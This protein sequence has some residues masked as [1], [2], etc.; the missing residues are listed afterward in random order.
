[1]FNMNERVY[2]PRSQIQSVPHQVSMFHPQA[3]QVIYPQPSMIH[4]QSYQV[5]HPQSYQVIHQQTSQAPVVSLQSSADP[6][7]VDS[8]LVVP[9]LLP[10]DDPLKCLN[11]V[12]TFMSTI[13]ALSYPSSN[14]QIETS[15]NP[16]HQVAMKERHALSYVDNSSK[17][18]DDMARKYTHSNTV[19]HAECFKKKMLLAQLQE[20]GIQL[21]D[22]VEVYDLDCDDVPD[23]QP[24]QG[25]QVRPSSVQSSVVNHSETK[26]TSDSNII[27]YSQYMKELQQTTINLENKSVNDSLT[28]EL[29]RYKEQVKVLKEGQKVDLKSKDNI[30]DSC[31]QSVKIDRLKQTLSEHLKEKESLMQTVTLLKNDFKKEESRNID[32]EIAIEKKIKQLDNIVYKRDQSTQTKAQQLKPKLYDGNVIKNTSAIMILDSK[33]TLMLAE[34]CRLKMLLKQQDLMVLEKKV[35]T[36]PVDYAILVLLEDPPKLRFRKNFLKSACSVARERHDHKKLKERIN[37]LSGN[38]NEDKV[39]KDIEEI[40]TINIELDHRVLAITALKEELRKLKGKSVVSCRESVN[41]PKVIAPVVH[42][43]ELE[44][45]SP[46]LKNNREAHVD[47]IRITKENVDTLRDVVKQAKTSNPLDKALA[48][49]LNDRARAK[50]VKS[51][52]MKEWKPTVPPKIPVKSTV[53]TNKKPSSASQWRLKETNHASSSSAPK[54]VE[55]RTANHLEPNN[56]M[57]SNVSISPSSSV[58]CKSY[59]SYLDNTSGPVP[60]RKERCTLQCALSSKEDKSS[61]KKDIV[62]YVSRYLTCLKVKTEHQRPFGLL[63]QPEIPK[64]KWKRIAM[65]FVTK[66][67]RTSSGHDTIWVISFHIDVLANN[68]R[69]IRNVIPLDEIRVDA[70][71]NFV[72]EPVEI[73]KREFKK[74]KQ[75]RIAIVKVVFGRRCIC[76]FDLAT[77]TLLSMDLLWFEMICDHPALASYVLAPA[78]ALDNAAKDDDI[79]CWYVPLHTRGEYRWPSSGQGD[80][81]YDGVDEVPKLSTIIAQQLQNLLPTILAQVGNQGSNQR[82]PRNQNGNAV[83]D[84]IQGDVR[85]VIVNNTTNGLIDGVRKAKSGSTLLF[86]CREEFCLVNEMQKLETEFWNHDKAGA[87]HVAYTDRFHELDRVVQK[88]GT[89]TDEAARIESQKKNREKR[90]NGGVPNRDRNVRDENKRT[91]T[92]NAFATT[93]N[94]VRRQYNGS[95]LKYVSCNLHHPPEIPCRPC[96]NCGRPRHMAKDCRVA[97]RMVNQMNARNPTDAPGACYEYGGTDHFKEACPR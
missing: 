13:L 97:P 48:Y 74:L 15:S 34:E 2:N 62:V 59:K 23:V 63:Q 7:L 36:T 50:A 9:Y 45:L 29:E 19:Q 93:T 57:G 95:I 53:I 80:E 47:Y 73:L 8:S 5:I 54:I 41:K 26:I 85:N 82:N 25:R 28:A 20:A 37:S 46:K 27:P 58:Q 35:N 66:L 77:V 89:L 78:G 69:G 18:N 3:S 11:K 43:V 91:R 84:N 1:M 70:K 33:K 96:F 39:K 38:M 72:E 90:G 86:N 51:N 67:P 14:N 10:T 21:T 24:V 56:H 55:S 64:W 75:S 83:N 32:R 94:P 61:M 81:V 12:L 4:P 16:M 30:L 68:A 92:R 6:I 17:S 87:G 22:G 52:K 44:P 60:Q 40:E 31:E 49:A 42:K 65:D 88:A 79:K 71:L 76:L